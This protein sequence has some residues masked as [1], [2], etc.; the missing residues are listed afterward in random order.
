MRFYANHDTIN[1]NNHQFIEELIKN[2]SIFER[3]EL[4]IKGKLYID[5]VELEGCSRKLPL[6]LFKCEFHGYEL[7]Y[8]HG[9]NNNL[10]CNDCLG[11]ALNDI[12]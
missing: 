1:L 6:Y 3:V 5:E 9:F 10:I 12:T 11:N 8:P 2:L 7:N 4:F